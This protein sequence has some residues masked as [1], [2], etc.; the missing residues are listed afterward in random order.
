MALTRSKS[1]KAKTYGTPTTPTSTTPKA[2]SPRATGGTPTATTPQTVTKPTTTRGV[3]PQQPA[4]IA[5]QEKFKQ[6]L[7]NNPIVKA[8]TQTIRDLTQTQKSYAHQR[9]TTESEKAFLQNKINVEKQKITEEENKLIDVELASNVNQIIGALESGK[10]LYPD[11]FQNNI[12][13][14]KNVQMFFEQ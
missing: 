4:G 3:T 6:Q 13:M 14:T 11:W 1:L 12:I 7:Q 2:Q 8:A 5:V 9:F 10:Q